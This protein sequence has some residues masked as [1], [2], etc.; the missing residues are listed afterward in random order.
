MFPSS[1]KQPST[2]AVSSNDRSMCG[3][4]DSGGLVLTTDPKP[5]LRWTAELHD[6]F[7]DAVAQLGGPDI[8]P[9]IRALFFSL[10]EIQAREAAQGVWGS[11]RFSNSCS[12]RFIGSNLTAKI[13]DIIVSCI[14]YFQ[15]FISIKIFFISSNT[16]S[17]KPHSAMEMQRNVAS[18]SGVMGRTMNDRSVNVN[19]ALRIQME[20][21]RRLHGELEVQK[22]L[23]MRVEAQGKYMQSIL[24]KAYQALGSSDC[25]TWPAGYR[26]LGGSQAVLDIGGSTSFS[27]V[28]DLQCFYGGSSHMDQ[29]MQME[30]PMDSFLTLGE[31]FIGS[32]ADKKGPNHCSSSGK[33]SMIWAGEEQQQAKSGADQL[34][35]GSST[36]MEGAI[37]V[38]DPITGLYEGAMSGDS[39]GSKGFE[40]PSSKLEIKSPPQQAPVGS[41]RVR[42]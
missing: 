5:R 33:S 14:Q 32:A 31:N 16:L 40:G 7:V 15:L 17:N 8:I 39:M 29:L 3:Q 6:R 21:Q 19:E 10:S 41:Q 34:Q 13:D 36:T 30:R 12:F 42:I 23:Q 18:S 20:V 4:G 1:K 22:H 37:D 38:M 28:Q 25:A 24:E 35:M 9:L 11:Y 26:S 27:S 2:G